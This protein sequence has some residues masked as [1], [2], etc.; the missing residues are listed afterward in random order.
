M[1]AT[2]R[3]IAVIQARTGSTR[4]P[5]KIFRTLRGLL[6][7]H[8]V[9]KRVERFAFID[10]M[11][12][13]TTGRAEDTPIERFAQH[14]GV[15]CVRTT[16]LVSDG[17]NDVLHRFVQAADLLKADQIMRITADCPFISPC[18]SAEVFYEHRRTNRTGYTSNVTPELDGFDTEIFARRWLD[19]ANQDATEDHDRHHVTPWIRAQ[20][21][22][23]DE[24]VYVH[25]P[26]VHGLK[27]SLDTEEDLLRLSLIATELT[28]LF[29]EWPDIVEAAE[30]LQLTSR[31]LEGAAHE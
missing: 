8:W 2:I 10:E 29:A 12:I 27:L 28:G 30:R 22:L 20:T 11:C 25:Q 3:T 21:L 7:L 31:A 23:S 16:K 18:L 26:Q 15:P 13:A 9:I 4:L 5:N 1:E 19:R 14:Q 24:H 6:V 17:R